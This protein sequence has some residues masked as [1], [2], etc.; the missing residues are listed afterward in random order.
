MV[1]LVVVADVVLTS[2]KL[3]KT[4][5]GGMQVDVVILYSHPKAFDPTVVP[6]PSLPIHREPAAKLIFNASA[7][8][9]AGVLYLEKGRHHQ[10]LSEYDSKGGEADQQPSGKKMQL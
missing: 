3:F 10:D 1:F 5:I 7:P 2:L 6:S 9:D 4:I 8:F